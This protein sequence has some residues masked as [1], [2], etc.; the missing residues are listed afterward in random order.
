M[1][2]TAA[3]CR[4]K[5]VHLSLYPEYKNGCEVA[6]YV[7]TPYVVIDGVLEYRNL[8]LLLLSP[9]RS[10]ACASHVIECFDCISARDELQPC[11]YRR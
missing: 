11:L 4:R 8:L 6:S 2:H 5:V 9:V 3:C 10:T 1:P 7:R